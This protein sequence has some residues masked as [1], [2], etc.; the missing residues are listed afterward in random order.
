[1]SYEFR[2]MEELAADF[3]RAV[4]EY[5]YEAEKALNRTGNKFRRKVIKKTP[6]S[7]REHKRK[8][9]KTYK[10][11]IAGIGDNIEWRFWSTAPHFHL[12]ERGHNIVNKRGETVGFVPGVH[13]VESTAQEFEGIVPD[14]MKKMLWKVTRNL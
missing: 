14:E 11:E 5:P 8:L 3:D 10:K 1:M 2:G 6:D 12:I 9:K 13:M 4:Q 7:G